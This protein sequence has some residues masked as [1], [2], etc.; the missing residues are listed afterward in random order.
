MSSFNHSTKH[1]ILQQSIEQQDFITNNVNAA[2]PITEDIAYNF[3][4]FEISYQ[5]NFSSAQPI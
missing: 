1:D 2:G 5:D 3:F 4:V